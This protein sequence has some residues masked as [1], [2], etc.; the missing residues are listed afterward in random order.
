MSKRDGS[1]LLTPSEVS[2]TFRVSGQT[3]LNWIERGALPAVV[4]P[5]GEDPKRCEYRIHPDH[6]RDALGGE[7]LP[8]DFWDNLTN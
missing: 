3:V 6:L 5:Q 8:P 1:K 7:P 2:R 4:L